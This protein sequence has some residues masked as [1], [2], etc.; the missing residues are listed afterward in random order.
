[1]ANIEKTTTTKVTKITAKK[2]LVLKVPFLATEK[3]A[4]RQV[5]MT[6]DVKQAASLRAVYE[7]LEVDHAKLASGR[8]VANPQ[9]AL[10]WLLE[11][12]AAAA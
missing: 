4:Q 8:R 2:G 1:M 5:H 12:V 11:A 3:Y 9:D 10:R 7:G 6:L